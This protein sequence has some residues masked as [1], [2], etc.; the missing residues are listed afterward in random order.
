[1]PEITVLKIPLENAM[2]L[3]CLS[4]EV[5]E[6]TITGHCLF[7]VGELQL[8]ILATDNRNKLSMSKIDISSGMVMNFTADPRK[9]LKLIKTVESDSL[10]LGFVPEDM[11]LQIFL[12]DDKESYVSL[13][14]FDPKDYAPIADNFEKAFDLK[15]VNAGVF[16]GGIQFIKGLLDQKDQKFSNMY[17]TKG[18]MYGSNGNNKAGAFSSP[19]LNGLDELVFPI[20]TFPAITNLIE[21]IDLQDILISTSSNNIFISSP[22]K[23]SIYGFTKVQIKMPKI[24]INVDEPAFGGWALDKSTLLKKLGRLQLSGDSKMGVRCEFLDDKIN[25]STLA[26]RSS[27]DSMFCT[28]I[29][30]PEKTTCLTECRLLENVL[31]QFGGNEIDFY[32][33]NKIILFKKGELEFIVEGVKQTKPFISAAAVSL[34]RGE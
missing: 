14:S 24:P 28:R 31:S 26:D 33:K 25:L 6:N 4:T 7:E 2:K 30:E 17:I 15:T 21:T 16:L 9:I 20:S 12:S 22:A 18:V 23:N 13:P 8:K 5:S 1:M 34:S 19:D 11:T 3:A 32:V 27:K 29:K 10:K